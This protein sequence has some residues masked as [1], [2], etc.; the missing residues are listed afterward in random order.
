[1]PATTLAGINSAVDIGGVHVSTGVVIV[2]AIVLVAIVIFVATKLIGRI[3][4]SVATAV[5]IGYLQHW[6]YIHVW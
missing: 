6:G 1:M 2:V 5:V 4:V 3:I